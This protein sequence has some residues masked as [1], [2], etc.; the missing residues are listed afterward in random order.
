MPTFEQALTTNLELLKTLDLTYIP[1][2]GDERLLLLEAFN[3]REVDKYHKFVAQ[4]KS[5]LLLYAKSD[6]LDI[7]AVDY[8]VSRLSGE[9]DEAFRQRVADSVFWPFNGGLY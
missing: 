7:V 8:G 6:A 2:E 3:Y 5:L 1:I 4:L 9:S